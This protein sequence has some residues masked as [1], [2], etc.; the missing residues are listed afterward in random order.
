M[1]VN[2]YGQFYEVEAYK[3]QY[4]NNG[5]LAIELVCCDDG[6]PFTTLTVNIMDGGAHDNYAYVDTNNFSSAVE[7]IKENKLGV[8]TGIYGYSGWCKYPLYK[9]Y[10][11]KLKNMKNL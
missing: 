9:F 8:F 6:C 7:F 3:G 2:C 1:K 11:T 10:K 5:S 4:A